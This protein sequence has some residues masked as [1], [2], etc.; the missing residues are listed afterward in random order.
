MATFNANQSMVGVD[1][2]NTNTAAQFALLT[3]V[4]GSSDSQWVYVY[5]SG[6]CSAGAAVVVSGTGTAAMA[7]IALAMAPANEIAF[8]QSAFT[9]ADYGWVCRSGQAVSVGMSA[10]TAAVTTALYVGT[11]AGHLSTTVGSAT[12]FG[13]Q[14]P[15]S[16]ATAIAYTATGTVSWPRIGN[17]NLTDS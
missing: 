13:V 10:T 12:V 16:S 5:M 14:V 2:N 1:L 15:G 8:A 7:T 9:A 11:V 4:A 3:R 17:A 6:A